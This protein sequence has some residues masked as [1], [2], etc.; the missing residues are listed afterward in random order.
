MQEFSDVVLMKKPVNA[1]RGR[2]LQKVSWGDHLLLLNTWKA[3]LV[4][5]LILAHIHIRTQTQTHNQILCMILKHILNSQLHCYVWPAV[6]GRDDA[7]RHL[8][9]STPHFAHSSAVMP[10]R[11][12]FEWQ[13]DI[14]YIQCVQVSWRP[15]YPHSRGCL[16]LSWTGTWRSDAINLSLDTLIMQ[17]YF[18]VGLSLHYF[19]LTTLTS[20]LLTA[21]WGGICRCK[22]SLIWCTLE[23]NRWGQYFNQTCIFNH[24]K[25]WNQVHNYC[26]F[27]CANYMFSNLLIYK[28][29]YKETYDL[30]CQGKLHEF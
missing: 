29:S 14:S 6:S 24:M 20:N 16:T 25:C 7:R 13:D 8:S 3:L 10:L 5:G 30:C 17:W 1:D 23:R 27:S 4:L 2:A 18:S 11:G 12:A 26:S 22:Y 15:H 19:S 9:I 21:P 28:G